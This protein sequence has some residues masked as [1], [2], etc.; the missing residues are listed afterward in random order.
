MKCSDC[1]HWRTIK[2]TYNLANEDLENAGLLDCFAKREPEN[3][4]IN[5]SSTAALVFMAIGI[6]LSLVF[7]FILIFT[8]DW[9]RSS[10]DNIN[11]VV[12]FLFPCVWILVGYI[13]FARGWAAY[14]RN[15][16]HMLSSFGWCILFIAAWL[17][18]FLIGAWMHWTDCYGDQHV[19]SC[20]HVINAIPDCLLPVPFMLFGLVLV[21]I[22]KKK[23]EGKDRDPNWIYHK[24]VKKS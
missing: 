18:I 15:K 4:R 13:M 14:S 2:C 11:P 24:P 22:G 9:A 21:Y 1:K 10:T 6:T 23:N 3:E 19:N 16:M 17:E 8:W 7:L 5:R 20:E 12:L